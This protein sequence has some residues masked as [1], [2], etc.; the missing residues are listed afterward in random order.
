MGNT[1]VFYAGSLEKHRLSG[2]AEEQN[3]H[4]TQGVAPREDSSW[5][6]SVPLPKSMFESPENMNK[7][8][9]LEIQ[10]KNSE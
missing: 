9:F 2:D 3:H 10:K 5:R 8:L 7:R 4:S 1:V 6:L